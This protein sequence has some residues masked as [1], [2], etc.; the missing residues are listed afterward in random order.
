MR[1]QSLTAGLSLLC[2]SASFSSLCSMCQRQWDGGWRW[3]AATHKRTHFP[4]ST[5][6]NTTLMGESVSGRGQTTD[7]ISLV[8][9]LLL[10]LLLL[11]PGPCSRPLGG[12]RVTLSTPLPVARLDAEHCRRSRSSLR[13][14]ESFWHASVW[15]VGVPRHLFPG[16]LHHHLSFS[17]SSSRYH[18]SP[19]LHGKVS[20]TSPQE[21]QTTVVHNPADGTKVSLIVSAMSKH[22]PQ[23]TPARWLLAV[24]FVLQ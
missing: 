3:G 5:T 6:A 4:H 11:R 1:I 16:A 9:L 21:A 23:L 24:C 20:P 22:K 2:P 14:P 13:P 17:S 15:L 19:S 12:P 10:F 18:P 7:W 8:Q